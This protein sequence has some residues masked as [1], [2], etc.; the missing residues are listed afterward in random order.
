M[1]AQDTQSTEGAQVSIE[2][3]FSS[4]GVRTD[5]LRQR[6]EQAIQQISDA[7]ARV[8]GLEPLAERVEVARHGTVVDVYFNP[9]D[10]HGAV[11]WRTAQSAVSDYEVAD[12]TWFTTGT[13]KMTMI[14]Q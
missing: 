1:S 12:M 4:D 7:H 10:C 14:E 13:L 5:D 8:Y 2:Q 9:D 6:D 11:D 3:K